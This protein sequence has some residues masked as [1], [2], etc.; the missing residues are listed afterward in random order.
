MFSERLGRGCLG[1]FKAVSKGFLISKP[2][3]HLL[4]DKKEVIR[5]GV[6]VKEESPKPDLQPELKKAVFPGDTKKTLIDGKLVYHEP[7]LLFGGVETSDEKVLNFALIQEEGKKKLLPVVTS[8]FF[9]DD[10]QKYSGTDLDVLLK[11][12]QKSYFS[13]V[14]YGNRHYGSPI[15]YLLKHPEN[16]SI[17]EEKLFDF[18]LAKDANGVSRIATLNSESTLDILNL[19][20]DSNWKV[21]LSAEAQEETLFTRWVLRGDLAVTKKLLELDPSVIQQIKGHSD[22]VFIRSVL[23]GNYLQTKILLDAI[24]SQNVS[25]SPQEN[26]IVKAVRNDCSFSEAEF[27]SL[28]QDLKQKIY[29]VANTFCHDELVIKLNSFGMGDKWVFDSDLDIF[30]YNMDVVTAKSVMKEFLSELKND[31]LLLTEEE[32]D[33]LDKSKYFCKYEQIGR[34]QGRNFVENTAKKFG[35]KHIKAPKKNSGIEKRKHIVKLS[36]V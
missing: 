14:C 1:V 15:Q 13:G 19:L 21:D 23:K 16:K 18:F 29:Y 28:E 2:T 35:C 31:G 26:W 20:Q 30:A 5:F 4:A 27:A 34:I 12:A 17:T 33:L 9:S 8:S 11:L 24:E 25:L 3:R 32:F 22:S 6:L 7:Q 36:F 10:Y